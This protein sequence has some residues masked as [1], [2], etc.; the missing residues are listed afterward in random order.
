VFDNP[1]HAGWQKLLTCDDGSAVVD[2]NT[3]ERRSVQ[4]VIRDKHAVNYLGSSGAFPSYGRGEIVVSGWQE[5]GVFQ[6]QDFRGFSASFTSANDK[7]T[8]VWR[9]GVGL[10]IEIEASGTRM[11]TCGGQCEDPLSSSCEGRCNES[12]RYEVANWHFRSCN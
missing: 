3:S 10:R 6:P 5:S 11:G 9:D 4:L 1:A 8:Y 2:V 7:T 12:Y